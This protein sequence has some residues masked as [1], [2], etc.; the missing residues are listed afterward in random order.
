MFA[1]NWFKKNSAGEESSQ[2]TKHV[3]RIITLIF[4]IMNPTS[5]DTHG[6]IMIFLKLNSKF[7]QA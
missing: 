3:N 4:L 7:V 1:Y 5:L 2:P 6:K